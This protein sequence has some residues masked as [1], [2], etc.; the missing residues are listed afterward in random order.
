MTIAAPPP[1]L[2]PDEYDEIEAAVASTARGRLFL[3]E[4]A[5]RARGAEGARMLAAIERLEARLEAQRALAPAEAFS[6]AD[7]LTELSWS[8]RESGVEDFVC[9]QID[10]L[11]QEFRGAGGGVTIIEKQATPEVEPALGPARAHENATAREREPSHPSTA[12]NAPAPE[13]IVIRP[14]ARLA[15]LSWLDRL[16]LIDRFALFA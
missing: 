12:L 13:P 16:P 10:A 4:H 3:A 2:Q 14:D 15:A 9:G 1:G 8:L 11:A 5:R 7:R 6:L